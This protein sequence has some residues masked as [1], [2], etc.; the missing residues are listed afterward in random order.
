M[1]EHMTGKELIAIEF[2]KNLNFITTVFGKS[3][4]FC[5]AT[6]PYELWVT[7]S[8]TTHMYFIRGSKN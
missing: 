7:T 5:R 6:R 1:G 3:A 2:K 4:V 8:F